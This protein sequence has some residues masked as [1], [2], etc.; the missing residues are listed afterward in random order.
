MKRGSIMLPR[1]QE[2]EDRLRKWRRR[3]RDRATLA[4][5]ARQALLQ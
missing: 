4:A 3:D 1:L 5:K 2:K